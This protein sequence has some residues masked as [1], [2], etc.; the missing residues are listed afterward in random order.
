MGAFAGHKLQLLFV[1]N[2]RQAG[3]LGWR[4]VAMTQQHQQFGD[5]LHCQSQHLPP[6][7]C[8]ELLPWKAP[9]RPEGPWQWNKQE[10]SKIM[11]NLPPLLPKGLYSHQV[12]QYPWEG[13]VLKPSSEYWLTA[14]LESE[15]LEEPE[16]CPVTK[17]PCLPVSLKA[18]HMES[19]WLALPCHLRLSPSPVIMTH[20]VEKRPCVCIWYPVMGLKQAELLPSS[21]YTLGLGQLL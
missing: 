21:K 7:T 2:V 1:L 9:C 17:I 3:R 15:W 16:L 8:P 19:S 10:G 14:S 5:S 18:C 20:V 6:S 4:K 12:S 11:L 13:L